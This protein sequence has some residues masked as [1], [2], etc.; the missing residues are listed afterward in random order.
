[1]TNEY[2]IDLLNSRVEEF[3]EEYRLKKRNTLSSDEYIVHF[4]NIIYEFYNTHK[5]DFPWRQTDNPYHIVVSEIMLQQ[6]Q[7]DRVVEKYSSFIKRFP[8]LQDLAGASL[9][10]V[11]AE[12]QGLGYNR[13]GKFLHKMAQ[14]IVARHNSTIPRSPEILETLPGIGK[15]TASSICAF[16]FNM[17]VVFIETNIRT[18]F[19]Y[20]FFPGRDDVTDKEIVPYI[21][22]TLD[23]QKPYHWYSALM[24]YGVMLKKHKVN[25]GRRSNHYRK[26][27]AFKGSIREARGR[28][29]REM[30]TKP[31]LTLSEIAGIIDKDE[32]ETRR[33][34]DDLIKEEMIVYLDSLY[35]VR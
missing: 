19:I 25:P 9:S 16:A 30:L 34:L 6:T 7:T 11:L 5:R 14:E 1:M 26:Q 22:K 32:A 24:D 18:L 33:I 8:T 4:R 10:D 31:G 12:W 15:A 3:H 23:T 29:L 27:A 17:P 35:S 13:R 28:I 20:F 21:E 2:S